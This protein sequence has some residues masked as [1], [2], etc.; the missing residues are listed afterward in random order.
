MHGIPTLLSKYICMQ[1]VLFA[2]KVQFLYNIIVYLNTLNQLIQK[3]TLTF[4]QFEF[5]SIENIHLL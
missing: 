5:I 4:F 2:L 1:Q 3:K